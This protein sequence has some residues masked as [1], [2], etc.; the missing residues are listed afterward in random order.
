MCSGRRNR[1]QARSV[2]WV[3][4]EC[5]S[6][7]WLVAGFS[8]IFR[9]ILR[10]IPWKVSVC[11]VRKFHSHDVHVSTDK[12]VCW[13]PTRPQFHACTIRIPVLHN[14][15]IVVAASHWDH[16][17]AKFWLPE[18]TALQAHG[19]STASPSANAWKGSVQFFER[20]RLQ[21]ITARL[22]TDFMPV[23]LHLATLVWAG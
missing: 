3:L 9:W 6:S 5:S 13:N 2:F 18:I 19:W 4:I 21:L 23:T 8:E 14:R 15:Q 20:H 12:K 22:D 1:P 10:C 16:Q 7:L 17:S 11:G